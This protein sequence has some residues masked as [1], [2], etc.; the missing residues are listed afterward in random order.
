MSAL[1]ITPFD[2]A[3]IL[4]VL[5]ATLGYLNRRFLKLPQSIALTV[6]G[7]VASLIV[8]GI[9]RMLPG[10]AVSHD[11]VRFIAGIDF[12]TTLMD[13][14]L[15][16]LLFAGA[17]HVDW[18]E[19]RRGRWPIVVLSTIGV[20]L[21]TALIGLGF[22]LIAGWL[23][24]AI[25]IA[26]CLVFGALI[27]P[28]D[29]VA[30]MG[31]MKEAAVPPTL[32]ATVAG[33]S[34]FNDGVGVV[35]FAIIL[36]AALSG[37]PLSVPDAAKLFAVEAGGGILL[38]LATGWLAYRAMHSIDD[39]KVEVMISLAVVMG[40]Y[41]LASQLHV[42]GPVAMAVAGLIIG[43]QGVAHAMSDTT[44]D[45]LIKFWA[46]IDDILNAVLFLLIGL[47]VVTIPSDGRLIVLG[48]A[49]IPLVLIARGISVVG[50]LA[51]M[52]PFLSLGKLAPI[53]LIWGG[54][55]GG[56]SVA[57]A[58]GL[59][60]GPAR[61]YALAATYI[62]VLFSVIVQGGT[63]ERVIR[64]RSGPSNPSSGDA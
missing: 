63:I 13:G 15:S 30:V 61:S 21:S 14:M 28:T 39:Y 45:Y 52:R 34:L 19:M 16:F 18:S 12:H 38:G 41:A 27:S 31:I 48:L 58:L 37:Q 32:Q 1:A 22:Q 33:E 4:I 9:D 29:P 10:S 44:S 55:R 24:V 49:S 2:A 5:A 6:M 35:V 54:L 8:V 23:G 17:L 62:V 42:S 47:E 36:A 11:I 43:N 40:G 26:W 46:L 3:A 7:A 57:L 59:P 25:P 64:W 56:I 53:T 20:I 50:P 51:V 60:S